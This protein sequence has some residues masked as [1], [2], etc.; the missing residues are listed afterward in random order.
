[1]HAFDTVLEK[2]REI[3]FSKEGLGSRFER[4]MQAYLFTDAK[5]MLLASKMYAIERFLYSNTRKAGADEDCICRLYLSKK[6][7][8]IAVPVDDLGFWT[9][10]LLE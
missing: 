2:Y 9:S 8:W 10:K 4:L 1:M 7:L 3:A 6:I 5:N